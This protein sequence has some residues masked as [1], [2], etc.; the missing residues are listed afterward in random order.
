MAGVANSE[1]ME[2]IVTADQFYSLVTPITDVHELNWHGL[3]PLGLM[4]D[5]GP[6][7]L[8][9]LMMVCEENNEFH[10]ISYCQ[11]LCTMN[12]PIQDAAFFRLAIGDKNPYLVF[13]PWA[14]PLASL[15]D[16]DIVAKLGC[17]LHEIYRRLKA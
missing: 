3:E 12:R 13:N 1:R 6:S 14:D 11:N 5:L 9:N 4:G 17:E 15:I 16:E 8:A 2:L 10:I 7:Q